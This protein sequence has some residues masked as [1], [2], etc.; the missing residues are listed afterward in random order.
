MVG[1]SQVLFPIV[2]LLALNGLFVGILNAYDH[3]TIPA[4][5][6]LVWNF[7]IIGVLVVLK[8]YFEGPNEM[9]AYAIGVLAG[10]VVQLAMCLPVLRKL[11]F[12][13]E[14]KVDFRDARVR[15]VLALMLPITLSLGPDQLQPVHQ[16]GA[17]RDGLRGRPARDRRR[18]PAVH[19]A[20]GDVQRRRRDGPVPGARAAGDA[21][22][23]RRPARADRHRHAPDLPA[24]DPGGGLHARARRADHAPRL[25]A[26]RVRARLDG[27]RRRGAVLV[28]LQPAVRGRQPA[29]DA[30]VLLAAAALA[31][32]R[33]GRG[34]ARRQPRR[35]AGARR[36][37]RDRR[38]RL[39]DRR[40]ERRDDRRPGVLPAP[41][42]RRAAR[43]RRDARAVARIL[44]ASVALAAVAYLALARPRRA[45]RPL[46]AGAGRLRRQRPG[47]RD[48][49]L[50]RGRARAARA[51]GAADPRHRRG[52]LR[53]R[54]PPTPPPPPASPPPASV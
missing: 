36:A 19:A 53:R 30:D 17:R 12:D 8:P 4:L 16:L 1:L 47:R 48:R 44:V 52:R 35:R 5:A 49:R 7:V 41:R 20:A 39:R 33:P 25:R 10:T 38:D 27:D 14:W 50:L 54:R 21:A 46:A 34:H 26:R 42:A 32:D 43:G 22:R 31:A 45:A 15:Q 29:A 37:V 51:R 24:A 28:L 40:R 9:Y 6:P 2:L 18:V 13:F 3:F 23:L 11:G